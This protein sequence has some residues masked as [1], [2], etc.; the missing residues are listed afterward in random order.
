MRYCCESFFAF[1]IFA[2]CQFLIVLLSDDHKLPNDLKLIAV[3]IKLKASGTHQGTLI[4]DEDTEVEATNKTIQLPE[5]LNTFYI[6]SETN[7]ITKIK[8]T[9][10][11]EW[12][13]T[14]MNSIQ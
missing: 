12:I 9:G 5:E 1:A 11:T 7:Q 3:P 14:I 6:N 4:L 10:K 2:M 8:V 13:V